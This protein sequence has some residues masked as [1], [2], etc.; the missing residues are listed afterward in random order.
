MDAWL[1]ETNAGFAYGEGVW[2]WHPW[3]G[4]KSARWW[5]RGWRWLRG[6]GHRG[7]HV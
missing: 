1:R 3:A 5:S 7:D 6:H 2:S 4:A